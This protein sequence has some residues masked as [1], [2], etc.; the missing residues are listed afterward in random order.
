MKRITD[1]AEIDIEFP[2]KT[3][4]GA[5]GRDS[6]FEIAADEIGVKLKLVRP[7]EDR[8]VA[9]L[10]LHFYLLADIV[11]EMAAMLKKDRGLDDLHRERL[12]DAADALRRALAPKRR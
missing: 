11:E 4:M 3:Y 9:E 8:R 2:D 7:G 1:K 6:G 5:F 12:A 10:H